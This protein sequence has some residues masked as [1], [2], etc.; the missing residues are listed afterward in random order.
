MSK[1]FLKR[2]LWGFNK[3]TPVKVK[4]KLRTVVQIKCC[5]MLNECSDESGMDP[6]LKE[7]ILH[8]G[9]KARQQLSYKIECER[10]IINRGLQ[11]SQKIF[12]IARV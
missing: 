1:S 10:D 9:D 11:R 6:T 12:P 3:V 2:L 7:S 4:C 5:A 8:G